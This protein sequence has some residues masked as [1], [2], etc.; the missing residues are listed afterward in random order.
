MKP[1][2]FCSFIATLILL[3]GCQGLTANT[4]L[5]AL[6][7][8]P[9]EASRAALKATLSGLFGGQEITLADNA[10]TQ[11][12][13]LSLE[14]NLRKQLSSQLAIGRVVTGPLSFQLIKNKNGCFLID[15]RD[16]KRYLLIDTT[17]APE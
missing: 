7:V 5:P 4:D 9:N 10:L 2:Q 1:R 12:S 15:S 13:M 16:G 17:C 14:M 3:S 8:Q 11:S 6:I